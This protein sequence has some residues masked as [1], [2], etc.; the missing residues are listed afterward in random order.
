MSHTCPKCSFVM[1]CHLGSFKTHVRY[2]GRSDE[3]FWAKVSKGDGCWL[4]TGAL[5]RDGY[6][7]FARKVGG[8]HVTI[9]SHR[10]AYER[11]VGPIPEGMDLLH[12]CDVRHCVNPAHLKPGT[13]LENM[14]DKIKRDRTGHKLK[15]DDVR[16]IKVLLREKRLTKVAIGA[17]FGVSDSFIGDISRG[18][19]W[20]HVQ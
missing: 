9:S 17:M 7:H 15:A 8:K 14:R 5:Q 20:T 13:H 11:L 4:W 16:R 12:S 18:R 2:C 6:A 19:K 10:Y 3:L 1:D